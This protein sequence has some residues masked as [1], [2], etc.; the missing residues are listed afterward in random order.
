M[1]HLDPLSTEKPSKN[2]SELINPPKNALKV[3]FSVL[4]RDEN[5]SMAPHYYPRMRQWLQNS[6]QI[7]V[8]GSRIPSKSASTAPEFYPYRRQWLQIAVPEYVKALDYYTG[9]CQRL[10]RIS[11]LQSMSDKFCRR[12]VIYWLKS[13]RD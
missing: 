11:A 7:G 10:L 13:G 1:K 8:N 12:S 4:N 6:I 2:S 5:A 9:M 3:K